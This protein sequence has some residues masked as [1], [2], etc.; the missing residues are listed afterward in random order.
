M[1]LWS[2]HVLLL[3]FLSPLLVQGFTLEN[4]PTFVTVSENFTVD[5][6]SDPS[7]DPVN[8][9]VIVYDQTRTPAC[10]VSE[11]THYEGAASVQDVSSGKG[12]VSFPLVPH[13][14]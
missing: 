3:S 6:M 14:G 12:Q 7:T 1:K 11:I 10:L 13:S 2:F 5:W 9:T 8:I 4:I